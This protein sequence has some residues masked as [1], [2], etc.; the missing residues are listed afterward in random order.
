VARGII[1]PASSWSPV[2]MREG[3]TAKSPRFRGNFRRRLALSSYRLRLHGLNGGGGSPGR[4]RLRGQF[5]DMQGKCREFLGNRALL[6]EDG[7][8]FSSPTAG[9][10]KNS[11]R[12]GT[13]NLLAR[14]GN[15]FRGAG[16]SWEAMPASKARRLGQPI[17]LRARA[18]DEHSAH[19]G[20]SGCVASRRFHFGFHSAEFWHTTGEST[21]RKSIL[22]IPTQHI[23]RKIDDLHKQATRL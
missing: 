4:T 2:R 21:M 18:R 11:L 7:P 8:R 14:T 23:R 15:L 5:P 6:A 19:L 12:P 9:L 16:N 22:R 20:G 13:G 17:R 3:S 1:L 10:A